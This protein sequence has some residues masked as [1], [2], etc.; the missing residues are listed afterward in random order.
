VIDETERLCADAD[1]WG[2]YG[3]IGLKNGINFFWVGP[4]Q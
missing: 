4:S 2:A 1:A 3:S